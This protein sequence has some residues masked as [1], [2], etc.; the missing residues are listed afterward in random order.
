MQKDIYLNDKFN[1]PSVS[2]II[3]FFAGAAWLDEAIE[4]AI[5][6]SYPV[7]EIIVVND[8]S[9]ENIEDTEKKYKGRV[10][11]LKQ[12]NK[13]AA[14]ARNFGIMSAKGD[15]VAFLDSDDLW[16]P[17]KIKYQVDRMVNGNR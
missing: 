6:Q 12:E 5:L 7:F 2:V 9:K 13:G 15:I 4:S 16:E 14:A 3:P 10:T 11:F 8:G 17:D 1:N